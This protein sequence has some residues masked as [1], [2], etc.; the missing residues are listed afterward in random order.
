MFSCPA[1]GTLHSLEHSFKSRLDCNPS[2]AYFQSVSIIYQFRE[3]T[4]KDINYVNSGSRG[5]LACFQLHQ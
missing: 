3:L 4:N 1:A 2:G 5:I